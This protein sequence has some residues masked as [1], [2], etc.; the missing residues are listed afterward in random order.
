MKVNEVENIISEINRIHYEFSEYVFQYLEKVNLKKNTEPNIEHIL[1][2][3]LH[4]HECINDYLM[5]AEFTNNSF[6]YRVKTS[7]SI[8]DKIERYD[9]KDD[10]YPLNKWMNDIFGIRI[11]VE[12]EQEQVILEM[13]EKWKSKYQL[14]RYYK[15]NK[16]GYKG[17]HLYFKNDNNMYYPWEMQVW[18]KSDLDSNI[19]SHVEHK[20]RF[21]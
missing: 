21:V 18:T 3:R 10:K 11:I 5:K 14:Q 1:K 2:Y 13:L 15:R 20:R 16:D 4:L 6:V 17:I 19:T 7:E 9:G 12:D 8:I